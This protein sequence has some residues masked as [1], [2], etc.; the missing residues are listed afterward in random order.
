MA[1]GWRRYPEYDRKDFGATIW[2]ALCSVERS[3]NWLAQQSGINK[4]TISTI[5][6]G[7]R[8]SSPDQRRQ[9]AQ[10]L[11][12]LLEAD[13]R[14]AEA[15]Q[16]IRSAGLTTDSVAGPESVNAEANAPRALGSV[17][18]LLIHA[19]GLRCRHELGQIERAEQCFESAAAVAGATGNVRLQ[20]RALLNRAYLRFEVGDP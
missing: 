3:A 7:R 2:R 15:S 16:L 11:G 10:A 5:L 4:G 14:P 6:S 8:A 12:A 17:D 13:G 1:K 19:E 20:A 18:A 9:I